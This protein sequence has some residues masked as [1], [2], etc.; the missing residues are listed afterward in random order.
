MTFCAVGLCHVLVGPRQ[1]YQGVFDPAPDHTGLWVEHPRKKRG[2][3]M[4]D[5]ALISHDSI[6]LQNIKDRKNYENEYIS[7]AVRQ[8][9]KRSA[10]TVIHEVSGLWW[11]FVNSF[12][13][14]LGR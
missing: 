6:T 1:Q 14:R 9:D 8:I 11:S 2:T 4:F 7:W 3:I 10:T 12:D 13:Q 5:V